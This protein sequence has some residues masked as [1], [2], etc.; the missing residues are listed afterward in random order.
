MKWE[1]ITGTKQL[2]TA[3]QIRPESLLV[4]RPPGVIR[5]RVSDKYLTKINPRHCS[6]TPL[7]MCL[8]AEKDGDFHLELESTMEWDIA[9]AHAIVRLAGKNVYKY[10]AFTE[11]EYDKMRLTNEPFIVA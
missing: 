5:P 6:L 8:V 9:A 7:R 4:S 2:R 10:P 1:R 11:V 3:K